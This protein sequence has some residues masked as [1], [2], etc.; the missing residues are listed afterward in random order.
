MKYGFVKLRNN[1]GS[2]L[3]MEPKEFERYSSYDVF[4]NHA[5]SV[6]IYKNIHIGCFPL[7]FKEEEITEFNN[8]AIIINELP[9]LDIIF[10]N[11]KVSSALKKMGCLNV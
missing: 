5:E 1:D 9:I 3:Y 7:M 11:Y 8:D 6:V 4:R 2:V 10:R